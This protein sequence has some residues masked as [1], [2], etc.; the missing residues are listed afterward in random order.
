MHRLTPQE[1]TFSKEYAATGDATYAATKAQY[2]HP[3]T[4]SARVL[5]R[6]DVKAEVD[7]HLKGILAKGAEKGAAFLVRVVDDEREPTKLRIQA[8][9]VLIKADQGYDEAKRG[10]REP[11]EMSIDEIQSKLAALEAEAGNRA[12]EIGGNA[13]VF[14]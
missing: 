12:K 13:S 2:S 6:Q 7:R 14:E 9:T 5:A 4:S 10:E 1:R 11:H 3:A 8:A